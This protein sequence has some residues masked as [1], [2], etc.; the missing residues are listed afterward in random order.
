MRI[1]QPTRSRCRSCGAL[2]VW[3]VTANGNKVPLDIHFVE[4]ALAV[5]QFTDDGPM[6]KKVALVRTHFETCPNADAH[7][8]TVGVTP[9][10]QHQLFEQR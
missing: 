9:D 4:D 6:V 5:V 7:R 2:V 10:Q 1:P 8:K 3:G